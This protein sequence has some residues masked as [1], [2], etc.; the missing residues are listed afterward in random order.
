MRRP[1]LEIAS[2]AAGILLGIVAFATGEGRPEMTFVG[3]LLL[4]S[5]SIGIAIGAEEARRKKKS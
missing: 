2:G 1:W 3:V 4:L 5:G